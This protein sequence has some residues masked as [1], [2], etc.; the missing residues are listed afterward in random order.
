MEYLIC[1]SHQKLTNFQIAN[2]FYNSKSEQYFAAMEPCWQHL[3]RA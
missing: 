3:R 2:L 1:L